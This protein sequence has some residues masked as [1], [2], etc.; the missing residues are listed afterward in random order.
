MPQIFVIGDSHTR[1]LKTAVP[2]FDRSDMKVDFHI[3]WR[4]SIKNGVT[5]GDIELSEAKKSISK[6]QVNDMLVISILG[7]MHNIL[8]LIKH[9]QPFYT[10]DSKLDKSISDGYELIPA[11]C[12]QD[13]FYNQWEKSNILSDLKS[14]SIAPVYH[15]MPPP[16]KENIEFI[17][18]KTSNYRGSVIDENNLN[19][20]DFR[21]ALWQLEM[22][23][24][25]KFLCD[26]GVKMLM[27]PN[28]SLSEHGYLKEQY[29]AN[30]ATHA[31]AEYG[32]LV[33]NQLADM[34]KDN[35]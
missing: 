35:E 4:M 8:G 1:A 11:K 28:Q 17:K 15:L 3:H 25:E 16:P 27:P 20:S 12:M 5:R 9:S 34:L 24:L 30:D 29:F 22:Y 6:L 7:T 19:K 31:N 14:L 18:S 32:L 10:I 33:L 2:S 13:F 23:A 26:M 21:L